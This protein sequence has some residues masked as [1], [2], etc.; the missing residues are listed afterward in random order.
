MINAARPQ[1]HGATIKILIATPY[2]RGGRMRRIVRDFLRGSAVIVT[3]VSGTF[4]DHWA[5]DA[6]S[7]YTKDSKRL[8]F[9]V[10]LAPTGLVTAYEY[11]FHEAIS[12]GLATGIMIDPYVYVPLIGRAAFHPFNLASIHDR[13]AVRDKL[14]VF[15]G[16]AMGFEFGADAPNPFVFREYLGAKYYFDSKFGVFLEDCG[17]LGFLTIGLVIKL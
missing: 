16:L 8:Q 7:A 3:I 4:A 14:D 5:N 11:G 13:I 1:G 17:G 9:G 12:G 2:D 10:A 6:G 15:A